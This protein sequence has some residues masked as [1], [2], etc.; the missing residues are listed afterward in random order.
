MKSVRF[1]HQST[2]VDDKLHLIGGS[3]IE[4]PLVATETVIIG[5]H[6]AIQTCNVPSMHNERIYFGMC[7]F[8]G[9]IF[10]AGGHQINIGSLDKCEVYTSESAKW[11]E[12]AN[13]N[14]KRSSLALIYFE[15][16]LWAIG[17][18][19]N[20]KSLDT[21]ETYNLADNKWTTIDIKLLSK[22][23]CHSAIVQNTKFF[24][25]GGSNG[26]EILSSVDVYSSE[27]N[28]F[29]FVSSMNLS[30]ASFGCCLINTSLFVIGGII[31]PRSDE[32]T[33][34]VEIYRI[35]NDVWEKGPSLPLKLACFGC[36]STEQ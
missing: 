16:R 3:N 34:E 15:D 32:T 35:E 36:S 23:R 14:T 17:G 5:E 31:D 28:Q 2:I 13:M 11:T 9:C 29:T 26:K 4:K 19:S 20:N 21:I 24:V 12:A 8:A 10:V 33:D 30:R 18:N 25:I 1:S 27:T 7:S 6:V 22:R